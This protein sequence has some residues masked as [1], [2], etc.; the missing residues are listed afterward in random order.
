MD[1]RDAV[2]AA[3]YKALHAGDDFRSNQRIVRPDGVECH[4]HENAELIRDKE[5]GTI[6]G[7]VGTIQD[8]TS[9]KQ[10]EE[11]LRQSQKM[12]AVG[13]G[14]GDGFGP[15]EQIAIGVD[16][17]RGAGAITTLK[18][19]LFLSVSVHPAP[20]LTDPWD[21]FTFDPLLTEVPPS[22]FPA[23]PFPAA[24]YATQSII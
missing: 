14:E 21:E 18:S 16:R 6:I 13:V 24:P 2:E 4:V 5:S 9:Q 12:E 1:D 22:P 19:K 20:F 8:V 15:P 7:L 3:V 11:Q 10:L 23:V 17:L